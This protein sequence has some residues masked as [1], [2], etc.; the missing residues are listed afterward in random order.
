M[1]IKVDYKHYAPT[2]RA[3]RRCRCKDCDAALVAYDAARR[4]RVKDAL[5][6]WDARHGTVGGYGWWRCRCDDCRKVASQKR[7]R[8][9]ARAAKRITPNDPRHGTDTYYLNHGCRCIPCKK[10][11][12]AARAARRKKPVDA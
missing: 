10:A 2:S 9:R 1:T 8:D 3:N 6:P 12:A 4:E 5:P 11:A 7:D